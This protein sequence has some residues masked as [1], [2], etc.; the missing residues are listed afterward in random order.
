MD[1]KTLSDSDLD[2]LE[3]RTFRDREGFAK[4]AEQAQRDYQVANSNLHA[5]RGE[6]E[7]RAGNKSE[8][9]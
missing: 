8:T 6:Q 5:I 7:K 4:K 2:L 1:I 3:L 9:D